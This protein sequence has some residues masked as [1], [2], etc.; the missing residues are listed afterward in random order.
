[1]MTIAYKGLEN[2]DR[3][4]VLWQYACLTLIWIVWGERNVRFFRMQ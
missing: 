3:G 2:S 1:M 4:L